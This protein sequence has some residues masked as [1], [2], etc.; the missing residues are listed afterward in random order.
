MELGEINTRRDMGPE[1]SNPVEQ[2]RVGD[3]GE[4][5]RSDT[6]RHCAGGR[7]F[8]RHSILCVKPRLKFFSQYHRSEV[9]L[10]TDDGTMFSIIHNSSDTEAVHVHMQ[11]DLDNIQ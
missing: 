10:Y 2:G 7:E 5:V 4:V 8:Q 11:Q 3:K 9:G 1:H 6:M